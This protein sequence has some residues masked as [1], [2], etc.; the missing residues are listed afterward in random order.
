MNRII[1]ID[2]CSANIIFPA[3]EQGLPTV[4]RTAVGGRLIKAAILLAEA[5]RQVSVMGEAG[6]DPLGNMIVACL[7]QAGIDTTCIDR[8]S[9]GI[10]T[11][12]TLIFQPADPARPVDSI[13]YADD[14]TEHWDSVWPRVDGGDIVVFG[15]FFALK[16]RVRT[17]LTEFITEAKQ[18]GAVIVNLPGFN[19][20]MSPAVTRV[21]PALLE[22]LEMS[23]V[24]IT[25]TTDL[26]H[27][28]GDASARACYDKKI[29]FYAR[30]MINVNP[31]T[32]TLK[33][34]YGNTTLERP[35]KEDICAPA[36]MLSP[37]PLAQLVDAFQ[38]LG[39]TPAMVGHLS[40]AT[41]D[42]IADIVAS[43]NLSANIIL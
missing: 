27:L 2:G 33:L 13:V 42:A 16:Q 43:D 7:N 40:T 41:L 38:Q 30:L 10:A 21:M 20:T 18:R 8:Y 28:F 17:R 35:L 37:K 9:N 12:S 19:P 14:V 36:P 39:I 24:V 15:G 25:A 31:A 22:D 26:S 1:I 6:R 4:T 3:T 23:D 32:R 5:G 29:S 34:M 11:P